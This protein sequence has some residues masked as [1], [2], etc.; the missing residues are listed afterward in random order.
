MDCVELERT[1]AGL[2]KELAASREAEGALRAQLEELASFQALPVKVDNLMKQVSRLN[3]LSGE[4][5][6]EMGGVTFSCVFVLPQVCELTEELCAVQTERDGLLST[7]AQ[8]QEEAQQFR[9]SLQTSRDEILKIQAD[10]NAAAL[11]E[12]ELSQQCADV[13]QQLDSLHSDLQRRDA[14][15][16]RLVSAVEE[17]GL[18]VRHGG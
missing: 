14:E 18:K 1:V 10:L 8:V 13:T 16:S 12:T 3:V 4:R 15:T 7:Q 2:N 9:D 5:L 17:T 11:R 6:I